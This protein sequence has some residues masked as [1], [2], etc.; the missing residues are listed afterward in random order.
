LRRHYRPD[1]PHPH[2]ELEAFLLEAKL[3][4]HALPYEMKRT[5]I[6]FAHTSNEYG[7]LLLKGLPA[8]LLLPPTPA[9]SRRCPLKNTYLSEFWLA[10]VGEG[11]GEPVAY[12]Q[13]KEGQLFQ[14]VCPTRHNA[15]QLS[16]ES[17]TILLDFHTEI[18]FHPYLPDFI[19]L[20]CLRPD[21]E[22]HAQTIFASVRFMDPLIPP[23]YRAV[24]FEKAFKT[25]VDY[26]FGSVSGMKGNGPILP[27][28][29]GD[30]YDPFMKYDLDL[31][32]GLNAQAQEA[33]QRM[34]QAAN[35][36]KNFVRLDTGDL[37]IID[38]RRAVHGRSQFTARYDGMDRWLQRMLVVRDLPKEHG[39][40]RVIETVFN[41]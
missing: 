21:H 28:L 9:D 17:S 37:L 12:A 14:D 31:M 3:T 2:E 10:V 27:V 16:S 8:D 4:F 20:Y 1:L 36:T 5:V 34:R 18:A 39:H 38:N 24:L 23:A 30:P 26:S 33:L 35:Q 29:Y 7:A 32:E 6:E 41:V 22:R 13:E 25:G 19:L 15:E 40:K 11:L